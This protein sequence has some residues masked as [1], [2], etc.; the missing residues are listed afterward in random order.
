MNIDNELKKLAYH[1]KD[2]IDRFTRNNEREILER[3]QS[4]IR[5]KV[6]HGNTG[7]NDLRDLKWYIDGVILG[8][9]FKDKGKITERGVVE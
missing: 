3:I 6:F 4:E 8:M 1:N 9:A 5:N 7:V 2:Q